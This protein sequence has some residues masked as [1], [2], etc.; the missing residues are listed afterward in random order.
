MVPLLTT[1]TGAEENQN[2]HNFG[3]LC[4]NLNVNSENKCF[5]VFG[6]DDVGERK[7]WEYSVNACREMGDWYDLASIGS[8]CEQ[9]PILEIPTGLDFTTTESDGVGDDFT[10]WKAGQPDSHND[11]ENCVSTSREKAPGYGSWRNAPPVT[12]LLPQPTN[13]NK[14]FNVFGRDDVGERKSWEYS[15]N[16]CR[17]MGDWY[18]LASIGSACEQGTSSES[19]QSTATIV[20]TCR[21]SG[22]NYVDYLGECNQILNSPRIWASARHLCQYD[23][24]DLAFI[25]SFQENA[26]L[27][28]YATENKESI[29][30]RLSD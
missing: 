10:N 2:D 21:S 7:S 25:H 12:D 14:C 15:V 28:F 20:L 18:D 5:N 29:W 26:F 22:V 8:A 4:T 27:E 16:A 17:E 30:T 24:A 19:D 23:G 11:Q 6:R 3:Q 1:Q 13:E 9:G